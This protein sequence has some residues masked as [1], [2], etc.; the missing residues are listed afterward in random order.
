MGITEAPEFTANIK[1]VFEIHIF[2]L[3]LNP[4]EETIEKFRNACTTNGMKPLLLFLQYDDGA[5]GVLQSSCYVSGDFATAYAKSLENVEALKSAGFEVVRNKIEALASNEGVPQKENDPMQPNLYFEFHILVSKLDN[6]PLELE[7]ID[8]LVDTSQ[9]LSS[10]LQ[11][12]IPLSWNYLKPSQRFLNTRTYNIGREESSKMVD[13]IST[14]VIDH[15]LKIAKVISEYIVYDT[16]KA[17][18]NGWL[19]P[20]PI[21]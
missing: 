11:L 14:K 8:F 7:D 1:G 20:R 12:C 17:L 2:V 6:S 9:K 10:D 4:N 15:N 16:N 21:S 18:D 13:L 3:P 5:K 19:E